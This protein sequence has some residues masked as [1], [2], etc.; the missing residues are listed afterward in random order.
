MVSS[1]LDPD[2]VLDSIVSNAVRL[3]GTDG[4][5][6]MEYV[7]ETDAFVVR[8]AYGSSPQLLDRLHN[9]I[10]RR[11]ASLV[12][13]AVTEARTL[14]VSDLAAV[15]RDRTW[16]RCSPTAGARCWRSR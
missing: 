9:V 4:G 15:S 12:G 5:S 3:T 8:A 7:E 14:Q 6:I 1:T 16:R 13:R 11:A 10:I 2:T